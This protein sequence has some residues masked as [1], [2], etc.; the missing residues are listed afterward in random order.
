M[1]TKK[2]VC[3]ICGQEIKWHENFFRFKVKSSSFV[4]YVNEGLLGAD[5]RH[6]DLCS[7]CLNEIAN[8]VN[9]KENEK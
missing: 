8:R 7:N 6:F 1:V 9:T 3:D 4:T 2:R 5:V